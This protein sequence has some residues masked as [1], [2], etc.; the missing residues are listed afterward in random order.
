M[1][2]KT[3]KDEFTAYLEDTSN[4]PGDAAILYIPETVSDIQEALAACRAGKMPLTCS[5]GRTGTTGGCVPR[6]GAILSLEKFDRIIDIDPKK[7]TARVQAGVRLEDLTAELTGEGLAL[8]AQPTE[9]LAFLGG[10]VSTAASGMRG[11]KYG[12]IRNYV[13]F[14]KIVLADGTLLQLKRGD[15]IA[16]GRLF[17]FE[18]SGRRFS[19]SLPAYTMPAVKHQAGYFVQDDMDLIDLFIGSEGTLGVI[20]EIGLSLQK[21]PPHIFD[22]VVF[23]DSQEKA[24]DFVDMVKDLKDQGLADPVSLEFFDDHSLRFLESRYP[25]VETYKAAVYFEQESG[26]DIEAAI[27]SWLE[28]I[29]MSGA[30]AD[31]TWFGDSEHERAKIFEFR[32]TL[33][34]MINEFLK[35]HGQE[36][37]SC[38]IAVP[39]EALREMYYF[40]RQ[41]A[42]ESGISFLNFGHIGENHLHFNFL[43]RERT[44]VKKAKEYALIFAD[45]AVSLGG[46]ISAEHGVGKLKKP[47]LLRMYGE[48]HIRGMARLKKYFDPDCILGSDNIFDQGYCREK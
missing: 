10:A 23:F 24:L 34:Q 2:I 14:L 43:P 13:N 15:I 8:R 37:V 30:D 29:E 21:L 41:K 26:D 1:I 9:S 45:K 18:R 47:Y 6:Q 46:T 42:G 4:L 27:G 48:F 40:Y 25:Q 44:E 11:F 3:D 16:E 31:K 28:R 22:C 12:G 7:F 5:A 36:K 19:F 20:V 35:E 33:P 39:R 38:D 17:D 32:H